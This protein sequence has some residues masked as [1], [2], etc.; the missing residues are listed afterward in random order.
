MTPDVRL[1][2]L[3]GRH[4]LLFKRT[5]PPLSLSLSAFPLLPLPLLTSDFPKTLGGR[6]PAEQSQSHH[7]DLSK[8]SLGGGDTREKE[9]GRGGR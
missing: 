5:F 6:R 1:G 2:S 8:H 4:A 9:E 7:L 3:E